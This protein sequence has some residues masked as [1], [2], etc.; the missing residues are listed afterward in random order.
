MT[1]GRTLINFAN[2]TDRKNAQLDQ[3]GADVFDD[4][5]AI[6]PIH[7]DRVNE[8]DDDTSTTKEQDEIEQNR[9]AAAELAATR[10]AN[11]QR[12]AEEKRQQAEAEAA[13]E[14]LRRRQ[15]NE[16]KRLREEAERNRAGANELSPTDEESAAATPKPPPPTERPKFNRTVYPAPDEPICKLP[17]TPNLDVD[18]DAGYRFGTTTGSYVEF[19]QIASK[20]RKSYEISLKFRTTES[21]GLLFY[22]ADTRHT[23]FIALYMQDS[24]LHHVFNIASSR[25]SMVSR[26]EYSNNEWTTVVIT[27]QHTHGRLIINGEDIEDGEAPPPS[28]QMT[29]QA[30]FWFGG[31]N[32]TQLENMQQN[33]QN[34]NHEFRGCI[35]DMQI[36]GKD[37]GIPAMFPGVIPCSTQVESGVFIGSGGGHVKLRDR[38]RVGNDTNIELEIR[39][40]TTNALL[41]SVH[42]KKAFLILELIDGAVQLSVNDGDQMYKTKWHPNENESLCDGNW[43]TIKVIKSKFVITVQVD[44]VLSNPGL[45]LANKFD[46][47]TK[48]GL[49]LG[50]HPHLG[51]VRQVSV[52][53]SYIGCVRNVRI[54]DGEVEV[55]A[56]PNVVGDVQTNVC[57]TN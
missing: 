9:L 26:Y 49:F 53:K 33:L 57:P 13:E 41:L 6:A 35:T 5:I 38:F 36:G 27:R 25:A 11:E 34:I 7:F 42:G 48:R 50:G 10:L 1:I 20:I 55:I 52:R 51:R 28:R 14:E 43:H 18:F 21:E 8:I 39:P 15:Q 23:D 12:A 19:M 40:R 17:A 22:A 44:S 16:E 45:G 2:Y 24:H 56:N 47:D 46:A 31:I 54:N 30:P 37:L 32:V 3:C 29:V 4:T